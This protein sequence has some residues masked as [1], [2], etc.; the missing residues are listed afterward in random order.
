MNNGIERRQSPRYTFDIPVIGILFPKEALSAEKPAVETADTLTMLIHNRSDTGVLMES[1]VCFNRD[2]HVVLQVRYPDQDEWCCM[3]GKVAWAAVNPRNPSY[4]L[5]GLRTRK[6]P[7]EEE[8][9]IPSKGKRARRM[10]P[11]D[12]DFLINT[13]LFRAISQDTKCPLLNNMMPAELHPG[14]RLITQG[15]MGDSLYIIQEG[16][17]LVYLEKNDERYDIARCTVGEIVGEMSLLTTEPCNANVVA[18]SDMVVWRVPND[19]VV[20]CYKKY[21][22]LRDYLTELVT[23]RYSE[24]AHTADRCIGKYTIHEL[25]GQ[26]AWS[27][28]YKGVHEELEMPVA[29]KMLKHNIATDYDRMETFENEAK[30]IAQLNHE[31][32]VKVYD[33]EECYKTIFLVMEFI[34]G[35]SLAEL[36]HRIKR[37]P[38]VKALDYLIQLCNGLGYAHEHGIIHQDI[39]PDNIFLHHD[40]VKI[41]DFGLA[42]TPGNRDQNM[43]GTPHYMAP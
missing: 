42:R 18:E 23:S 12:L 29:I 10:Y 26:G 31:N 41:F 34:D 20:E 11:R 28:V 7:L 3:E 25:L 21:S 6:I 24:V 14:D 15:K 36:L 37:L 4:Y 33:I 2:E 16:D 5:M 13:N 39:K 9:L 30:I 1:P 40:L 19:K 35:I 22:D 32:I 8:D 43:P 17:C 27:I 38:L